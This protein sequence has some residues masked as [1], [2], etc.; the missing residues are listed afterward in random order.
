MSDALGHASGAER[1]ELAIRAV[2]AL[3]SETAGRVGWLERLKTWPWRLD[4]SAERD[5][6]AGAIFLSGAAMDPRVAAGLAALPHGVVGQA[7][8]RA[9]PEHPEAVAA[10][11]EANASP[12]MLG[13]MVRL[14]VHADRGI[15]R[16]ASDGVCRLLAAGLGLAGHGDTS[17]E[18]GR[19]GGGIGVGDAELLEV[20]RA[21]RLGVERYAEHEQRD[22]M[23]AALVLAEGPG[24]GLGGDVGVIGELMSDGSH[25]ACA[26]VKSAL[27]RG[28]GALMR[29]R[30]WRWLACGALRAAAAERVSRAMS[31][32]EHEIVLEDG[33]LMLRGARR[34]A[35]ATIKVRSRVTAHGEEA[36]E[37]EG[38]PTMAACAAMGP[39][40]RRWCGEFAEAMQASAG[41]RSAFAERGLSDASAWVRW[42][43]ARR[44]STVEQMD[45]TFDADERVAL[46]AT[47][48]RSVAGARQWLRFPMRAADRHRLR[49]VSLLTRSPHERVRMVARA[50]A[51]RLNPFLVRCSESRV[52]ARQWLEA[53]RDG[54]LREVRAR[55]LGRDEAEQVDALVLVRMLGLV[56]AVEPTVCAVMEGAGARSRVLATAVAAL[57][58]VRSVVSMGVVEE[59]LG[60]EDARVRA[61]A[62]E[63]SVRQGAGDAVGARLVELKGDAHHRVRANALRAVVQ[64]GEVEDGGAAWGGD[65]AEMLSDDRAEHRLAGLWLT[66]RTLVGAGRV[67]VPGV[68]D[69][70]CKR[71]A[72][73]ASR[74]EADVVRAR[75]ARCARRIV[76]EARV[77]RGV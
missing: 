27:R 3:G 20:V 6:L 49:S 35:L 55:L 63:A 9:L 66:E 77:M 53:D 50:D 4:A 73:L 24:R 2:G 44:G 45:Y 37:G 17:E 64:R 69:G 60:A 43:H 22:V 56:L 76:A 40:A 11:V 54:F 15:S 34:A 51:R 13:L 61:N 21:V 32:R 41:V 18:F 39:M 42:S 59:A 23:L 8:E 48:A 47:C 52:T 71:V 57:G 16:M 33:H 28:R 7:L 75:A 12:A 58:D 36:A 10:W 29:S 38:L 14:L 46:F 67:R 19:F 62:I 65:V 72:V 74:D 26:G 30:A 31:A 68:W 5:R 25:A 1:I 70:L